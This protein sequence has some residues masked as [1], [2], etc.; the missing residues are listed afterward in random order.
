M[1]RSVIVIGPERETCAAALLELPLFPLPRV[2]LF[3][4]ATLPLHVFEQRYRKMLATCL[5][6]HRMLAVVLVPSPHPV[7]HHGHPGIARIASVGFIT[8]HQSLPDGRSNL[9]LVGQARVSLEELPFEAPY[10]RARATLLHDVA[11]AVAA[12]D[13]SALVHTATTFAFEV[14]RREAGFSFHLPPD[15]TPGELA[16]ACAQH[17]VIDSELRQRALETLDVRERV[18][19]VTGELASQSAAL[20]SAPAHTL[21]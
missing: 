13:L 10:R 8:E 11:T 16:D 17:L 12:A 18:R 15:A 20:S 1:T 9:L 3:P 19:L 6:T 7:D 21:N 4:K 5:E 2:V 14:R